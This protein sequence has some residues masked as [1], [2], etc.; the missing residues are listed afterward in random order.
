MTLF[1]TFDWAE[2]AVQSFN[3]GTGDVKAG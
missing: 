1:E 2:D 3:P